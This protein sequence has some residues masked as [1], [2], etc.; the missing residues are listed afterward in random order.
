MAQNYAKPWIRTSVNVSPEF[1]QLCKKHQIKFST[2]MRIGISICLA[3]MGVIEYDNNLNITRRCQELKLKASHYAQ[4]ASDL[5]NEK[6]NKKEEIK[7]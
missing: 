2:A 7:K 4:K 1:Y 3:E 5:E 6:D